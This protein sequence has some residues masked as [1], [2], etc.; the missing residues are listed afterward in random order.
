MKIEENIPEKKAQ[1]FAM[2]ISAKEVYF[3]P[4]G[5]LEEDIHESLALLDKHFN[6]TIQRLDKRP[7]GH[8]ASSYRDGRNKSR[9]HKFSRKLSDAEKLGVINHIIR[10][11]K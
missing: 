10:K 2:K 11:N 6:R 1:S 8:N 9:C 4:E 3:N 7:K 5:E